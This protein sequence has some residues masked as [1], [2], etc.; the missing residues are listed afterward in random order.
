MKLMS[1]CFHLYFQHLPTSLCNATKAQE[2]KEL[3]ANIRW[4]LP[5]W[6]A[7]LPLRLHGKDIK[8]I[9]ATDEIG[10]KEA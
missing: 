5:P 1:E 10:V 7:T 8:K 6:S 3:L 2:S 4:I 9:Q